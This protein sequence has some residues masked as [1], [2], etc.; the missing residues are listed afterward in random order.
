MLARYI[1]FVHRSSR[2]IAEP[3]DW[4]QRLEAE[5]PFIYAFWH[6]QFL[7]IPT[8]SPPSIPVDVMVARHGDAEL[9]GQ[10][11]GH[12]DMGLIR[13][14]GAGDRK[15]DRGGAS[16]LR[17]ALKALEGGRSLSMTADVPPGPARRAG[18]GIV[19]LARLSGRPIIPVAVA[20]SR[21][22]VLDTWSRMTINLPY[23]TIG[24]AVGPPIR[25]A[26]ELSPDAAEAARL[27][28]ETGLNAVTER[29][30]RLA[31]ADPQRIAPR[32]GGRRG[33]WLPAYRGLTRVLTPAGPAILAWRTRKG[34][35][36]PERRGERLGIAAIPRPQGDLVWLHAASV[37]ETNAVLPMVHGLAERHPHLTTLLTTGTVTSA[38][39]A[40]SRL[41]KGALHQYVP[42]DS[43]RYV[44][45]FLAHWRPTLAI[46]VESEV[47]PNLVLETHRQ[48]I[49]LILANARMS[50]KSFQSW[51]RRRGM[52]KTLFG[53]FDLVLAQNETLA[54]RFARLGAPNTLAVGNLKID[55]PPPPVDEI[56]LQKL[57]QTLDG[58]PVFLA[59]STHAGEE[60]EIAEAYHL[61][62]VKQ[63]RLLAIIVPRH[64]ER[65]PQIAATLAAIG[66]RVSLRSKGELPGPE[67][68]IYVAD[69]LGELGTFYKLSPV[70][71]IGGSLIAH[72]GQN[73][74]EAV[75]LGAVCL[76]GPHWEN[77]KDEFGALIKAD[78]AREV[79]SSEALSAAIWT[80]AQDEGERAA[81]HRRAEAALATLAGALDRSL[82]LLDGYLTSERRLDRA[83]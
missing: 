65:G 47:W 21:S 11:L 36:D 71:F 19:T 10:A 4:L 56:A 20:S 6:G 31:G 13:G 7:L 44:G 51:K 14:A 67:H 53:A 32:T 69:T 82:D 42:L 66:F 68:Q 12:F 76:T 81:M 60:E 54:R 46:F 28:V 26:R 62:L 63:P 55:S 33:V 35:E 74:I 48:R 16:A 18:E 43:P 83:S 17:G 1:R 50:K 24:V 52:A 57:R 25:V 64:P 9:I 40:A 23:S 61:S 2:I 49:P 59:A 75:K 37:G 58:R 39:L 73:P 38:K 34:K 15:R 41:P 72:G 29:A 78:G 3:A 27:S 30:Y 5:Q 8:L 80:L 45:R 77:F 22:K 79:A 70:A